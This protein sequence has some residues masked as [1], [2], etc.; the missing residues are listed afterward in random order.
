MGHLLRFLGRLLTSRFRSHIAVEVEMMSLRQ[1]LAIYRRSIPRP[2]LRLRDRLFWCWLSG[3][4]SRWKDVLV[5]AVS[6][7]MRARAGPQRTKEPNH[8]PRRTQRTKTV[9]VLS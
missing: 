3:L 8:G 5:I 7:T 9:S 6:R 4:W 1:Q 2:R